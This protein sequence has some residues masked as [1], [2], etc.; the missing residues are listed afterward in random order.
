[1][2]WK[3]DSRVAARAEAVD[4][5]LRDYRAKLFPSLNAAAKAHGV[6]ESTLRA[7]KNGRVSRPQAREAQ[8]LLSASEE[9][10]LVR[11]I[12]DLSRSGFPPRKT[13]VKDMAE[14]LRKQRLIGINDASIELVSYPP[15]GA[16]WVDRF[17]QRHS[18]LKTVFARQIDAARL[19]ETKRE[20]LQQWFQTI[21]D[22]ICEYNVQ[23]EDI[24]NMDETGFA[25]G[26]TQAGCVLIDA[27]IRTKF[28][29]QPGRQEWVT[30]LECICPDGTVIPPL[31]IFK[32][33]QISTQWLVPPDLTD[34]WGWS[35]SRKGWTSNLHGL[36]WL[37]RCFEPVT[38]EKANGRYRILIL[39]GHESHVTPEFIHHCLFNN[40]LLLRLP[41][42]TSHIL[43]PLDVG[44]FG[45]LKKALSENIDPL[46][47]TEVVRIQKSEWLLAYVKA[48]QLAFTPSNILGGWRGAGLFPFEP[49]KVYRHLPDSSSPPEL[50]TFQPLPQVENSTL[51]P[52]LFTQSFI[53]SSPPNGETLRR[54]SSALRLETA[55]P[56]VLATPIRLCIPRLAATTER[57]Y[58]E[59]SILKTRLKA[60][61]DVLSARKVAKKGKRIALK[62]HLLLTTEEIY[63][64][65]AA[66]DTE[67]KE[68]Q[69]KRHARKRKR[70]AQ[71]SESESEDAASDPSEGLTVPT[72]VLD[73][74]VVERP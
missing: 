8:Q 42:H 30:V 41:Q 7:H 19:K 10:A 33:E 73:C 64:T 74:I 35:C 15:I 36:Y 11:W 56:K 25:I 71:E 22:T 28:Q 21:K 53:T 26:S 2:V 1:M 55:E 52:N 38:R 68:R 29:A 61:T 50:P 54:V 6:P 12:I 18:G 31:V 72:E 60:A 3:R 63:K 17:I 9:K 67:A 62:D 16:R 47:Q 34:G 14:E 70:K 4:A 37:R 46:I 57:L 40:I 5:A 23:V 43:Q 32:G 24:Y 51:D 49:E 65:V 66:L 44:L 48:R 45:P 59:N 58:A 69:K 27:Q 39:D 13:R 20:V